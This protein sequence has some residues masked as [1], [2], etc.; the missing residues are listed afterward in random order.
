M[1]TARQPSRLAFTLVELLV[2]I[3]IIG[4]LVSLLLPAVNAAREAARRTQCINHLKQVGIAIHNHHAAHGELVSTRLPCEFGTWATQLWPYIEQAA[5][6]EQW[7]PDV[8]YYFQPDHVRTVLISIYFCPTRRQPQISINEGGQTEPLAVGGLSDYCAV[9]GIDEADW[10]YQVKDGPFSRGPIVEPKLIGIDEPVAKHVLCDVA[11]G[12]YH[13]YTSHTK[14][15]RIT[16]GLSKTIFVG[17]KQ[18]EERCFGYGNNP[19]SFYPWDPEC[20]D[21]SVYNGDDLPH[22]GR[23]AGPLHELGRGPLEPH[24]NNFGSWHTGICNFAFG[25]GSVHSLQNEMDTAVLGNLANRSD[26]RV[27]DASSF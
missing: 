4:I 26:G 15:S 27:V 13:G 11:N 22:V 20:D 12:I 1:S 25:D 14:F 6:S 21:A 10:D 19:F 8:R 9:A 24:K 7:V 18:L 5:V 16:D 17:E 23:F 3:A 2:V